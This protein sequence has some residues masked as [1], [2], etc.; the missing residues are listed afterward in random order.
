MQFAGQRTDMDLNPIGEPHDILI[1]LSD[2]VV[3]DPG[4]IMVTGITPQQTQADG[5]TEADFLKIFASEIS[6]PGTIFV[7]FN[8]VRFDDEFMRFLQYRNYYDP[9][10]WQ[11]LDN[12]S[13]WDILDMVRMTRALRPEGIKWPVASDGKPANRLELLTSINGL[14]HEHAHDA[15]SDVNATIALAKLLKDKQPK[16]FD[17]LL[18]MRD[19]KKIAEL[20]G[21]GQPFVYASGKYASE[22]EKTTV[23]VK[24]ADHPQR[25]S[26]LVYDLRHDPADFVSL[27]AENIV[28]YWTRKWDDPAPRLPVKTLQYNRCPAVAPL[29][30]LD[31]DAQKRL[32]IDLTVVEKN[33]KYLA[34][35]P[36]FVEN[37]L[38]ALDIMDKKQQASLLVDEQLVDA[39][40]Y[41]GFFDNEDKRSFPKI[42]MASP[43][44]LREMSPEF[45]DKRLN[46]LWPLYKARN[47]PKLLSSEERE[48]WEKYRTEK[49]LSGKEKRLERYFTQLEELGKSKHL[50]QKQ[51]YLLEELKLYG[52]SIIPDQDE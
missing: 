20:V 3:P 41:D 15:L 1:K 45:K 24:L 23:V 43:D 40:L 13:R 39:K 46:A 11:W 37:L 16:L 52:E 9:Y 35:H 27:S 22:F 51:K 10:E 28:T 8:S 18:T 30:V 44:E 14:S 12:R 48:T 5:I 38:K 36:E 33:R 50:N 2:D 29:G 21:K 47:Y 34:E 31:D 7:G 26:S 42:Q 17:Y 25:Q 6:K 4:A 32:K 19:K 49:L